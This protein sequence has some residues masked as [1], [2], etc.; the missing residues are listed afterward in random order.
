VAELA[1]SNTSRQGEVTDGNLL[2]YQGI[3][4]VVLTLSHSTNEDADTIL[5][6]HGFDILTNLDKW[7]IETQR[8]LAA[9]GGQVVSDRVLDHSEQFLVGVGGANR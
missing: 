6:I 9:V 1:A 4:E 2:I 8:D 3:G 5:G 7:R